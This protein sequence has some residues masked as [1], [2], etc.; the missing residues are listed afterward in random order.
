MI[1][2]PAL[3]LFFTDIDGALNESVELHCLG[4][5]AMAVLYQL[6]RPTADVDLLPVGSRFVNGYLIEFAGAGSLLHSKHKIHLQVVGVAPVPQLRGSI[7]RIMAGNIQ[8][9]ALVT[10]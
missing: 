3:E 1:V 8:A 10:A 2:F 7:S 4:G 9:P 6:D 5:F